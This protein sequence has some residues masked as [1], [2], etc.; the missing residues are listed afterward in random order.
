MKF[1]Y[2][3]IIDLVGLGTAFPLLIKQ[4]RFKKF[5]FDIFDH[6]AFQHLKRIIQ[7]I[8]TCFYTK[9]GKK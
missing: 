3:K 8:I 4:T 7:R 2:G 9:K 5:L 6:D 1:Y